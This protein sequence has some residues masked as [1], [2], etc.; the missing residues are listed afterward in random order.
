MF[1]HDSQ[2]VLLTIRQSAPVMA[3]Y[4]I[5]MYIRCYF[6]LGLVELNGQSAGGFGR[7]ED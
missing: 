1:R 6:G 3:I 4:I 7:L 5:Y 2:C